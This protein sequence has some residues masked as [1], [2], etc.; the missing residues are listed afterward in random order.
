MRLRRHW[1]KRRII[2]RSCRLAY[3]SRWQASETLP[4]EIVSRSIK[5]D[6]LRKPDYLPPV[7]IAA[8]LVAVIRTN[9]GVPMDEA[10]TEV[11]RLFGFKATSGRSYGRLCKMKSVCSRNKRLWSRETA[12]F[13][14]C[15]FNHIH[16]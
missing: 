15:I 14:L 12:S 2:V 4:S 7:E 9:L 13:T 10:I 6:E 1:R 3:S 8:A 11:A 5:V 16:A